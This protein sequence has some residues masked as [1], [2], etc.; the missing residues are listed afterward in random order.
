M[1]FWGEDTSYDL[2]L[3]VTNG[4]AAGTYELTD[5]AGADSA[6]IDPSGFTVYD[7]EV[8][9]SGRDTS[10]DY[11][12]WVTNGTAAG[13]YELTGIAGV[14]LTGLN[15]YDLNS[16]T[17]TLAPPQIPP[18]NF[19]NNVDEAG[20]LWRNA[21]GH[22]ELWNSNGSGGFTYDNLGVVNTSWQI[23]GT[24]AF[25]GA[26]EAGILW[27]NTNGDTELW[28]PNG[29]GGFTYQ[30]LGVVNTSWQ[31]AGTGDFSGN[32]EDG[33]LW[34]NANGDT[35][36]WNPNGSG[37]FSFEWIWASSMLADRRRLATSTGP[38]KPVSYG[39]TPTAR[40]ACG[41]PTAQG[42]FTFER[43]WASLAQ[44][45]RLPGTGDFTGDGEGSIL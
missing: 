25:N 11:G 22:T 6:G 35:G 38:V 31:V 43:I 41:I 23:A 45:G 1:L 12:L 39:A 40:P 28:N 3:W 29:S 14:S 19:F 15:P 37:G 2:G 5:I 32:G 42:G 10:G 30:D 21:N 8:L 34:R 33:I 24:G 20:I 26:S 17:P 44:T 4:T 36:L 18:P 27:R 16:F 9:F 7:G 13:T